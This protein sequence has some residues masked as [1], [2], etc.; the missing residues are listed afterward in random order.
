[1][2]EIWVITKA[3]L[4]I[5][6]GE[7]EEHPRQSRGGSGVITAKVT[8]KTGRVATA[9]VITQHDNDLM[10]ISATG[11]VI[12]QDVGLVK[13]AGRATQGVTLM[14]LSD[15]DTVVAVAT[16]NGKKLEPPL[17]SNDEVEQP[18]SNGEEETEV[19]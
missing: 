8:D 18:E 1:M 10:I 5:L 12:R 19:M 9:R 16:T 6:W 17:D 14:N 11:V 4:S 2:Q 15:G 3:W 13:R 7:I